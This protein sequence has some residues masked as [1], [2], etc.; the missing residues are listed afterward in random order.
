MCAKIDPQGPMIATFDSFE[1]R[2]PGAAPEMAM[3]LLSP[4]PEEGLEA[5]RTARRHFSGFLIAAGPVSDP[6]MILRALHDGAEHYLDESKAGEELPK[7][8][9]RLTGK[10]EAANPNGRLIAFL[11]ASGGSG[12]STLAVN[13]AAVLARELGTCGLLDLKPGRGDLAALLDLKPPFNL[14]DIC[15]NGN[16]LDRNMFE[17]ILAPHPSGIKLIASPQ[18]FGSTRMVTSQGV[19]QGLLWARKSFP[20]VV[21]DLEDCFHEEQMVAIRQA[22]NVVLVS[23]LDFTSLRNVRRILNHL[24]D[25]GVERGKL[26][27]VINRFGQA[28]E[29]PAQ[30]A[31][32][33]LGG[34]VTHLIPDDIKTINGANNTGVP[35]VLKSP[36][37][38]V[39]LALTELALDL[40]DRRKQGGDAALTDTGPLAM[41]R[42]VFGGRR[43]GSAPAK[44]QEAR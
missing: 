18:M 9:D 13:V 4:H 16:R 26:Q 17:K 23:R 39:S 28:N 43:P 15:L 10:E 25:D 35:A 34:K 41:F 1:R 24:H 3:V 7:V 37:A 38:K 40:F 29:L 6:Q 2:L 22:S 19:N 32:E 20:C 21:A 33:A 14:A 11:G 36:T 27:L 42:S 12:T 31:A 44:H 8:V 5:L 30:E